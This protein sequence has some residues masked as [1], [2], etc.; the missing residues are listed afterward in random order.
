[1]NKGGFAKVFLFCWDPY[2]RLNES[3]VY[4]GEAF[5]GELTSKNFS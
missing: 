2:K 1:M 3:G 5:K 4:L